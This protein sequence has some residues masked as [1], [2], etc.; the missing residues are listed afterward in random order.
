MHNSK[1]RLEVR[2]IPVSEINP[3]P[4]NPRIKQAPDSSAIKKMGKSLA[5]F[6]YILPLLWNQLTKHLVSGHLRFQVL[7]E[8]GVKPSRWWLSAS[9]WKRKSC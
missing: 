2:E 8:R 3:A 9:L 6:G 5:L 4:Y 1:L 7:L